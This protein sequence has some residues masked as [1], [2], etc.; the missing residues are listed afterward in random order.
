MTPIDDQARKAFGEPEEHTMSTEDK[1]PIKGVKLWGDG[2]DDDLSL[3]A[4]LGERGDKY[5]LFIDRHGYKET[6]PVTRVAVPVW[7]SDIEVTTSPDSQWVWSEPYRSLILKAMSTEDDRKA[8]QI[9]AAF[10]PL[11]GMGEK[12]TPGPWRCFQ[13]PH[14]SEICRHYWHIEGGD[15]LEHEATNSHGFSISGIVSEADACLMTAAPD[16]LAACKEVAERLLNEIE[17]SA[18]SGDYYHS[19]CVSSTTA[20]DCAEQLR[21]AIARATK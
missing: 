5:D 4:T 1:G 2:H 16:L 12:A 13:L 11:A 20:E 6:V 17:G 8:K 19:A 3:F 14:T 15:G 21:A 7:E 18:R 9:L 10:E